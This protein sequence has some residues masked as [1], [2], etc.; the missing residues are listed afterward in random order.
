MDDDELSKLA[1]IVPNLPRYE[2][3]VAKF[4]PW[5][6]SVTIPIKRIQGDSAG[7]GKTG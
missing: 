1:Y 2:V 3:D 7:N 5:W 4:W 6:D